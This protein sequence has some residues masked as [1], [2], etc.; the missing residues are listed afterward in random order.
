MNDFRNCDDCYGVPRFVRCNNHRSEANYIP[1]QK[2]FTSS[3]AIT[4]VTATDYLK[5]LS[6]TAARKKAEKEKRK[7]ETEENKKRGFWKPQ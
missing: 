3:N 7:A 6:V 4:G 2:T 1:L 5:D